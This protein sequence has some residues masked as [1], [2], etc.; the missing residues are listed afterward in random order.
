MNKF[1]LYL[2]LALSFPVM[3]SQAQ[4][5]GASVI[6]SRVAAP[7]AEEDAPALSDLKKLLDAPEEDIRAWA[8]IAA[9]KYKLRLS[10]ARVDKL[11][12]DPSS[13]IRQ[14]MALYPFLGDRQIRFII[15]TRDPQA[16]R[17][18]LDRNRT[19]PLP[20]G[21][22]MAM[23]KTEVNGI[24]QTLLAGNSQVKLSPAH[25]ALLAT[26]MDPLTRLLLAQGY[27]VGS[28]QEAMVVLLKTGSPDDIN[29][30]I[31]RMSVVP[32]EIAN[33]I[34]AGAPLTVRRHLMM[35]GRFTP[36]PSQI[37]IAL[38]DADS[39]IRIGLLR[40]RDLDLPAHVVS[41]G[42]FDPDED[43]AFWYR[44]RKEFHPTAAQ[45]E[46]G[47][48]SPRLLIRRGF[49]LDKE[50]L[51]NTA[52]VER[53]LTDADEV[54]R[55]AFAARK[56]ITLTDVQLDRCMVDTQF[57][58]RYACIQR[59]DFQLNQTRFEIL[60]HDKNPNM[61]SVFSDQN[62]KPLWDL[63]PFVWATLKFAPVTTRLALAKQ[64]VLSLNHEQIRMGL[65]ANED[66]VRA[67]FAALERR[68]A[69]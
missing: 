48:S 8:V 65:M 52:Q 46:I 53:G 10:D 28:V 63:S 59:P 69:R 34:L 47:L 41:A 33:T 66:E 54:V 37:A 43:V 26:R 4:P 42:M 22:I 14:Y 19:F 32:E 45:V 1:T 13:E 6:A 30:T 40:R 12:R 15:G 35:H 7:S 61:L 36:T 3:S 24:D 67:A 68:A 31:S 51:P 49:A 23:I 39:E 18:L 44:Q 27:G 56:N 60:L 21:A 38:N 2:L 62:R 9:V 16:M 25:I 17:M 57:Q 20:P 50:I 55:S 64:T 5:T 29:L 58:V 11:L